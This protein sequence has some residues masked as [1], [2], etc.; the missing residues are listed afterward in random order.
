MQPI[1]QPGTKTVMF[2]CATLAIF[3][4]TWNF[5]LDEHL[6]CIGELAPINLAINLVVA[7]S[8]VFLFHYSHP[9]IRL[10]PATILSFGGCL[11]FVLLFHF[12]HCNRPLQLYTDQISFI[13]IVLTVVSLLL[14]IWGGYTAVKQLQI[15]A[16]AS[17][18]TAQS[19]K[20]ASFQ[21]M[22][23]ILQK[24][25][26]RERRGR[27]F[28]MFDDQTRR[29]REPDAEKW[30]AENRKDV[31]DTLAEFDQIGLMVKYGLLDYEFLE[32]WDYTIY[33]I[34]HIARALQEKEEQKYVHRISTDS[35]TEFKSSYYLGVA[36]LRRLKKHE[37]DFEFPAEGTAAEKQ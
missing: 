35:G 7:F 13:E 18:E 24:E 25:S 22:L 34:L 4:F 5:Y 32:G 11:A 33:K 37:F 9:T 3:F 6:F 1:K 19:N 16:T 30:S 26:A 14:I 15:S 27:I 8:I 12:W 17:R 29:L 23:G 2:L 10:V 20:L 21:C 31:H 28:R 36:E